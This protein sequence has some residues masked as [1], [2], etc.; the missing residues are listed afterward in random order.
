MTVTTHPRERAGS[1][2]RRPAADT[3]VGTGAMI[4]LV[5]RRNR[6]RLAVWFVVLVGL[7]AYVTAYYKDILATQAALDDFAAVSNVPSIK[8]LTGLSAAA[9]TLGGAVWTKIWMT[10]ALSLAIGVVFLSTRNGRADEEVGRTE[11]LRSRPLGLHAGSTASWLIS[12]AL[13]VA[14]GAFVALVSW[15]GG[16]DPDGAG[17][18]GS[19]IVGASLTGV[20]LVG[21]GVGAVV[22][23][24]TSTSRGANA[25][26]SIILGVCYVIRMVGDLG[27]GRLTWASPV[28]WGQEM[29]PW[30]A[31]RWWPF[32]LLILL[33]AL[34]LALA[35][36]LEA[37]RDL[38]AGLFPERR[39]R[40]GA[41]ARYAT[42]LG[43]SLRLQRGPI[44]GWTATIVLTALLFGSVVKSMTTL[45]TD[46]GG[47]AADLMRGAGVE[48]LLSLLL[49]M[50]AMITTAFAIQSAV[51]LRSEEASGIIEPQLAG[52]L[53]R[54][55]WATHRLLIPVVGSA[56]LLLVG[57]AGM[58][59]GYGSII[60]DPSQ[61]GRL[62]LS[63]L[64]YWPAVMVFVGIAVALFGWL[65]RLAIPLTWA[66]LAGMWFVVVVGDALHL[67]HW[68]LNMLPFSATP[69]VP[70][71]ELTW[72]PLVVMTLVAVALVWAGLIRF[73]HR[74]I[75]PP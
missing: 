27:D 40:S 59:A 22:G 49:V 43:L 67:P 11:L 63:A 24:V 9:N 48:A 3:L 60:G 2:V 64:T 72:P 61:T 70:Y 39:G 50:I 25:L 23:Q 41:P 16:L 8:A 74:D 28:G 17:I 55:R 29:Q 18:T 15:I 31:N 56:V 33:T 12:A 57:G 10:S 38:G 4:R 58:G 46:A 54:T 19:L 71:Q 35:A 7:F 34:L 21:V 52:A 30:G 75:E 66:V 73:E 20:G 69:Y 6:V 53:S 65:P 37:R 62:A 32:F 26:G 42:P 1:T 14:V 68:L 47:I 36:R 44:I 51:S 5:L 45:M 13:C